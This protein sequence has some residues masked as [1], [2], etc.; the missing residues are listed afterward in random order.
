M[1]NIKKQCT[2]KQCIFLN[3]VKTMYSLRII[4]YLLMTFDRIL[5]DLVPKT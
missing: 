2:I 4:Y 5:P 1:R 3:F